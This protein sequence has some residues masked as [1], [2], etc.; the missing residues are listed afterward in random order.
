MRRG[1]GGLARDA[2]LQVETEKEGGSVGGSVGGWVGG[3]EREREGERDGGGEARME[4]GGREGGCE[5]GMGDETNFN[6]A[7][8][9]ERPAGPAH[10]NIFG[11]LWISLCPGVVGLLP[12][13]PDSTDSADSGPV[14]QVAQSPAHGYLVGRVAPS[15]APG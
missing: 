9:V 4:G 12:V 2:A 8:K 1:R 10:P 7:I 5:E 15:Q 14:G 11:Y 13:W 6:Q 3:R